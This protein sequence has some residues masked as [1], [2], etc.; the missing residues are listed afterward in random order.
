MEKK[1][2]LSVLQQVGTYPSVEEKAVLE[3]AAAMHR[4]ES[5]DIAIS[6]S[7]QERA[8]KFA[9]EHS[10]SE[11]LDLMFKLQDCPFGLGYDPE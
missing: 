4:A 11:V 3:L 2:D 7:A 10:L 5:T 1:V 9:N 8:Q 6:W